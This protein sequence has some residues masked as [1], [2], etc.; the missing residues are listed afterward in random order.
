MSYAKLPYA[1]ARRIRTRRLLPFAASLLLAGAR[2]LSAQETKP[3][4]ISADGLVRQTV[5]NEVAA[6]NN[7]V[8]KHMFRSRKQ[9][10]KGS[11][12]HLY[13]E[14]SD[15]MAGMLVA[16]NDHPLSQQQEQAE[17]GHLTWLENNPEQLR[18]KRIREKEDTEHTLRIMRAL[19]DAFHYEYEGTEAGQAS[20]GKAGDTLIRLKFRPNPAFVPPSHVEQALEGMQGYLLID[21][22]EHRIAEIDGNLFRDVT[23]GW[24]LV[25]RLDKGGRFHVEQANVGAGEWEITK[26]DLHFTGK[27]L[28]IKSFNMVSEEVFTDFQRV[29]DQISFA[30]GV[31][32]LKAEQEK[33]SGIGPVPASTQ[34][35]KSPQ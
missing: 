34:A 28:L 27:I 2:V 1:K 9:T 5:A 19:P 33:M 6:A 11:Q 3:P 16:V 22:Q 15:A 13:V 14:T 29:P 23:F 24:G 7:T 20:L 10:P 21:Q 17:E 25:G 30:Q 32:L 12:T 8:V 26:M 31:A 4:E 18:K 35:E